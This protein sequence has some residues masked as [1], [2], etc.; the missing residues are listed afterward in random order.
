MAKL[1]LHPLT[2]LEIGDRSHELEVME[3][4]VHETHGASETMRMLYEARFYD[5]RAPKPRRRK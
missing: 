3:A 5:M 2:F 1:N 4:R